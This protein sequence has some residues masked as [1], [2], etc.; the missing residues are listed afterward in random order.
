MTFEEATGGGYLPF[1]TMWC[2]KHVPSDDFISQ[3]VPIHFDAI[4]MFETR[5][6]KRIACR[7]IREALGIKK[8]A[9]ITEAFARCFFAKLS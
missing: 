2:S 7:R 5:G 9:R 8:G 3:E 4:S 6:E 1:A